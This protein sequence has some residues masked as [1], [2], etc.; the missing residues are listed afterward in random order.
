MT[1]Y[2]V[3]VTWCSWRREKACSKR[4]GGET[5]DTQYKAEPR[6]TRPFRSETIWLQY[7]RYDRERRQSSKESIERTSSVS[8]ETGHS[9]LQTSRR[10]PVEG[11]KARFKPY[12]ESA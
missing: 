12:L 4:W 10:A 5:V 9:I 1:Y 8:D 3:K 6:H 7:V 2:R 11:G